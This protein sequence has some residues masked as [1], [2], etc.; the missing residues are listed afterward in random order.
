[1]NY[2]VKEVFC[3]WCDLLGFGSPF[4]ESNWDLTDDRTQQNY[5]RIT[6]LSSQFQSM[7]F[8]LNERS[9][10]LNDG[11]IRSID[12]NKMSKNALSCIMWLEKTIENFI[13]LNR[14]DKDLGFPG[15][16][17]VLTFGHRYNYMSNQLTMADIT[18]ASETRLKELCNITLVY[19]PNEFQM[20]TAFS[21]AYIME[22]AGSNAGLSG[23]NLFIDRDF[24]DAFIKILN[25]KEAFF[26]LIDDEVKERERKGLK[27]TAEGYQPTILR[28]EEVID[29]DFYT[30]NFI[31]NVD[32][33][34]SLFFALYFD[35]E[36]ISFNSK[37]IN[38]DL[39]ALRAFTN[40]DLEGEKIFLS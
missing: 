30:I 2:D 26:I 24:V 14:M 33:N 38:T 12:L 37:G 7:N 27:V 23:A 22:S 9:L 11:F 39:F 31:N 35:K 6:R 4:V 5:M 40:I 10:V 17:G 34:D 28:I 29:D 16:R 8:E 36:A 13:Y 25:I 20:N 15:A 19:S 3:I 1:M 21:K 18:Q 32:G